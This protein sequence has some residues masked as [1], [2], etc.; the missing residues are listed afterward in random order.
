MG[1]LG[2]ILD[3]RRVLFVHSNPQDTEFLR[4]D[5]ELRTIK[6]TV[7]SGKQNII[8]ENLPAA[9]VDD[10]RT[11]LLHSAPY[12]I[13]HFSGHADADNLVFDDGK[14]N[15]HAV[16]LDAIAELLGRQQIKCVILNAC[17]TVRNMHKAVAPFTIGMDEDIEDKAANDFS[18]G[19]Y[20]ALS[21]EKRMRRHSRKD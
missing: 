10:L 12:E 15:T 5:A 13:V 6:Q 19:F 17:Q 2:R 21:V 4:L 7:E 18:R 8:V 9:T 3:T 1:E 16:S 20:D 11:H 14:G